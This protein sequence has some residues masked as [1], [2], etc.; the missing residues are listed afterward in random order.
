M[1][2]GPPDGLEETTRL[3]EN[4]DPKVRIPVLR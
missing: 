4:T 3:M 1:G 2:I